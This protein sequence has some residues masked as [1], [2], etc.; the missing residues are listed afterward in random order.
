[1]QHIQYA[2]D[3]FQMQDQLEL[4]KDFEKN[5]RRY[6]RFQILYGQFWLSAM[7]TE[8]EFHDQGDNVKQGD[9]LIPRCEGIAT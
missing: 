6:L 7:V 5:L 4:D 1:M 8:G 9:R 2:I 3:I